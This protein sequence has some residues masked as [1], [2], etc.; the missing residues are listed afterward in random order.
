MTSAKVGHA[1][2]KAID[3]QHMLN[4]PFSISAPQQALRPPA[5]RWV[6]EALWREVGHGESLEGGEN[7]SERPT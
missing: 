6:M 5:V 3:A 4:W 7:G 1:E 2:R